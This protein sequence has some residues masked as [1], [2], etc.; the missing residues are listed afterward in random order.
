MMV[1]VVGLILF[2]GVH[3]VPTSPELRDG[4][5]ERIGE[6][7]YKAIFSLLSLVGLVVIVLGY[8]KLQ[9]HPGKNPIL[10]DP[11]TWTRHIAVALMLPAMILLVASVIPS[12]IRT[13]V[14][15]PMLIAI[16]TWAFA[17]L[18]ANGDLGALL[19][20]GS[21]LAF[22]VYDRISVKKRGAQ[23]PLGN[24][25]PSSAIND[26]IVVVVGVALY[27]ALL[28]GGHQWLIGVAPIPQLG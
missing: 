11:P 17:H 15:H 22:A 19:L 23:G 25:T 13:A 14:R 27:A 12:R 24:A 18:I 9:L 28:Y 1:L 4:L 10:W 21:F 5:K 7:P 8:H 16:K 6:M 26:V 2:L 20:F 3:L